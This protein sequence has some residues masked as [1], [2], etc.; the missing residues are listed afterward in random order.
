MTRLP[1][2]ESYWVEEKRLL[3]GEYPGSRDPKVAH[4]RIDAFLK[5]GVTDFID[6]TEPHEL[7]PYE[8][9]LKEQAKIHG[10]Q[11]SY[12]RIPI[13]DCSIPTSDTMS[14]IL[15]SIEKAINNGNCVYVHCWGGVG[16]TGT[17]VGCY[18]VRHGRSNEQAIAQVDQLYKTRP[19]DIYHP[20]SPETD[21]QIE[22]IRNWWDDP[23]DL[24]RSLKYFCE[25]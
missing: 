10:V 9:I 23:D 3:A 20:H 24:N 7:V 6:L 12:Q 5:A 13:L 22:F 21:E 16:R 17:V 8:D 2:I 4:H 19:A 14:K 25:G 15:N 18:L 1:I 11:A